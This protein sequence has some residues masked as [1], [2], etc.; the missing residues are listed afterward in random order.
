MMNGRIVDSGGAELAEE[1]ED[2]GYE[3]VRSRLGIEAPRPAAAAVKADPF[4]D[5][6]F[7]N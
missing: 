3:A 1:L 4:S 6:P 2:G 7:E 5:L